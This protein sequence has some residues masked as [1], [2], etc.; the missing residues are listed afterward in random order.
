[1]PAETNPLLDVLL[2]R[3]VHGESPSK[4]RLDGP[5]SR[6]VSPT[7]K[8]RKS[9]NRSP[10]KATVKASAAAAIKVAGDKSKRD[11]AKPRATT[12]GRPSKAN[13]NRENKESRSGADEEQPTAGKQYRCKEVCS[14]CSFTLI[15]RTLEA[16]REN[17]RESHSYHASGSG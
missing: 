6:A 16:E 9:I 2:A 4:K 17:D 8:K 3:G 7:K 11:N 14:Q 10:L 15:I 5:G 13:T 1:M 12:K